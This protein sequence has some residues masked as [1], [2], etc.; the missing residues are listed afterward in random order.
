MLVFAEQLGKLL[1]L[2]ANHPCHAELLLREFL[3]RRWRV[4]VLESLLF[5][6]SGF[7]AITPPSLPHAGRLVRPRTNLLT[8]GALRINA[9]AG[10]RGQ[11]FR[12]LEIEPSMDADAPFDATW[13]VEPFPG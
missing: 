11:R 4:Q 3:Q 2:A 13:T 7:S 6:T 5:A 10:E 12:I 9:R 1:E 8:R